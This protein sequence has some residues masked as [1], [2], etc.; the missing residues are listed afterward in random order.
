MT[1]VHRTRPRVFCLFLFVFSSWTL[2]WA[3]G[4]CLG[5]Q[6]RACFPICYFWSWGEA[7]W[8]ESKERVA[9]I[10]REMLCR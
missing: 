6:P 3:T 7:W 8:V 2:E 1:C 9:E 5:A 4:P 10:Q